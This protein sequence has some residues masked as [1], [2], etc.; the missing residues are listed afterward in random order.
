MEIR[1][2]IFDSFLE[3]GRAPLVEEIIPHFKVDR[4]E[5]VNLLLELQA[6]HHIL[7]LPGT[8]RILMANP[9]SNLPTP[10]RVSSG[11]M[12]YYANCAWDAIAL[13]VLLEREV[14]IAS[15]CHHCGAAILLGLS[16]GKRIGDEGKD[17]LVYLGTPVSKWYDDL[18]VTCSNTMVFF[19]SREHLNEWKRSK[20]EADGEA[21]S[22]DKMVEVVTPISK[23]RS[24][25]DYQMPSRAQLMSHW[26][27][28]GLRGAFWTF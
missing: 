3:T 12:S 14:R 21:L 10:F 15:F 19:A 6:S 1:K 23:G 13:H 18:V 4:E 28:I 5:A 11:P 27:S 9:F 17:L 20:P 26:E 16:S 22:V 8:H 25:L 7:L 2:F 24:R